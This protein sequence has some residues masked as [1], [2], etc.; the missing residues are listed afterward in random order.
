MVSRRVRR[1]A[2]GLAG[3][4]LVPPL[5]WLGVVLVAPTAWARNHVVAVLEASSGRSVALSGMSVP[6]LGGLELRGLS[7]GS[8]RNTDD[9]W[10]TAKHIRVDVSAF[11]LM[12][13]RL[14]PCSI[15]ID[16]SQLRVMR[17]ADGSLELADLVLPPPRDKNGRYR[18]DHGS[19]PIT[20]QF[21]ETDV[22][23]IDEPSN[24]VLHLRSV[25]G[26]ASREGKRLV[27]HNMR[28]TLN[29]GPFQFSGQLDRSGEELA[30]ELKFR[31]E[32]VVLDDGMR[33]IRYAVPVLAGSTLDLKGQLDTDMHLQ[34]TGKTWP[35]IS[36]TLS[37]R[38]VVSINPIDL[39]GSPIVAELSKIVDLKRQGRVASIKTDFLI[40]SRRVAT[41]HFVLDV[42]RVPLSL[43]G[44]TDF[45]G[46]LDYRINLSGL[47]DRLPDQARRFL[48][49]LKVDMQTLKVLTLKGSIN[50]MVVQLNGVSLDRDFV[51]DA[52][53]RVKKQDREKLRVLGKKLLDELVR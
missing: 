3:V 8:P 34:A 24:S 41:D 14:G 45:D 31:A 50:Q 20:V 7:I 40:G 53:L 23:V 9:P 25:E 39:D 15:E 52:G 35:A 19:E 2:L 37:G 12:V 16:G 46:K 32:K 44:W 29:G 28:G 18:E 36:R 1:Y 48:S 47:N 43:A 26:D 17:R 27:V 33:L 42:G 49:D 4:A 21:R 11:Q 13:G 22:S 5:L 38:G 51:R 6:L 10:F 30:M